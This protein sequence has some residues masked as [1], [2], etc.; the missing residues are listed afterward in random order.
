MLNTIETNPHARH[1]MGL[2]NFIEEIWLDQLSGK[3][4]AGVVGGLPAMADM[5]LRHPNDCSIENIASHANMS[6]KTFERKFIEQV[7]ISPKLF[8]RIIRFNTAIALKMN[9]P[10]RSWTDIAHGCGYYD[11]MHFI[12]D[13]KL[14]S[15]ITPTQYFKRAHAP[16][17]DRP[18]ECTGREFGARAKKTSIIN[19]FS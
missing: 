4:I 19:K 7:G 17:A 2:K 14:F 9:N 15:G 8:S 5:I 6:I 1:L 10:E 12:K 3:K 13:F 18:D 16:K 11:Q